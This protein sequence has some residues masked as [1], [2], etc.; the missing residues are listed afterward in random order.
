MT[1]R[2]INIA[3]VTSTASTVSTQ[4]WS[5]DEPR[6]AAERADELASTWVARFKREGT[7]LVTVVVHDSQ[8]HP[9]TWTRVLDVTKL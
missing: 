9:T 6:A 4:Y 2:Y 8:S 1:G 7:P 3:G 5:T